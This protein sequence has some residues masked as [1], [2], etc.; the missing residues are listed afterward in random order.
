MGGGVNS[1]G[2]DREKGFNAG[3]VDSTPGWSI[4]DN[5]ADTSCV[6]AGDCDAMAGGADSKK[7][8]SASAQASTGA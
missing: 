2:G 4:N 1:R 6:C 5:N 3:A 8:K 7:E